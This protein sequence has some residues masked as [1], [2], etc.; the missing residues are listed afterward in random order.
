[1]KAIICTKYG[2]PDF[3]ELKEV[4]KPVPKDNKVL[5]KIFATTANAADTRIRNGTFPF[6]FWLP[7][8]LMLGF[9]GP[10]NVLGL[11]LAGEIESIGK[12]V[13]LFK[14]GDQVFGSSGMGMGAYAQYKCLSEKGVLAKKPANISYE[15]AAGVPHCALTAL[16]FLK[17]AKIN[18]GTVGQVLWGGGYRDMQYY[19]NGDG[20]IPG[21]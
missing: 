12:D 19:E 20:Q 15:E 11:E 16:H 21:G 9:K 1:M 13:K 2:S 3:L 14:K 8:R 10:R 6:L 4:A 18:C 5:I 7:M 17:K